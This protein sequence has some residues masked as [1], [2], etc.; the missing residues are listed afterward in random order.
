MNFQ[1]SELKTASLLCTA[2]SFSVQFVC[3]C[4]CVC[5]RVHGHVNCFCMQTHYVY[6]IYRYIYFISF[7]KLFIPKYYLKYVRKF[8]LLYKQSVSQSL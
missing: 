2:F 4:V 1:L 6:T 8:I 7:L 5:E 3:V